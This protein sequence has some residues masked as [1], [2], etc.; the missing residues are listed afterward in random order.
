[1]ELILFYYKISVHAYDGI[2]EIR[3]KLKKKKKLFFFNHPKEPV[4]F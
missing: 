1:M 2:L 4:A 3:E